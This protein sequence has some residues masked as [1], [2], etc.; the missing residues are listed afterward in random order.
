M[1]KGENSSKKHERKTDHKDIGHFT[2]KYPWIFINT[3]PAAIFPV[4]EAS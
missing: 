2:H 3:S 4:S 1:E